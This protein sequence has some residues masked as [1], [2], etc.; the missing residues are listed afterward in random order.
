MAFRFDRQRFIQMKYRDRAFVQKL[1]DPDKSLIEAF[2]DSDFEKAYRFI[3]RFFIII[4]CQNYVDHIGK[5]FLLKDI[6]MYFRALLSPNLT[7]KPFLRNGPFH[8]MVVRGTSHSLP[9]ADL[10]IQ[11]RFSSFSSNF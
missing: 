5:P 9:L 1:D 7:Q 11:Q 6:F 3:C 10:V 2:N 4:F 8:K